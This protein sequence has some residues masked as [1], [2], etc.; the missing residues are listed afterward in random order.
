MSAINH[1]PHTSVHIHIHLLLT[2]IQPVTTIS[3]HST[4]LYSHSTHL[5]SQCTFIQP[6]TIILSRHW[7][8]RLNDDWQTEWWVVGWWKFCT[9]G[10]H[11]RK[12][13]DTSKTS[14]HEN[15]LFQVGTSDFSA[16]LG[17]SSAQ[18]LSIFF[19]HNILI[20]IH[21]FVI[22][23]PIPFYFQPIRCNFWF[24]HLGSV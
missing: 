6:V 12:P 18:I 5:Y 13:V 2:F 4:H 8:Y 9:S 7:F 20:K 14:R 23:I 1:S 10:D 17:F 22:I 3:T 24:T 11:Y 19:F 16:G 21:F 15:K